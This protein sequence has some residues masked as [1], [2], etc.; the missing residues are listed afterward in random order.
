MS[1]PFR[2]DATNLV[3]RPQTYEELQTRPDFRA[4]LDHKAFALRRVLTD[5]HFPKDVPCGLKS[6]RQPHQHGY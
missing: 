4:P 6:C 3:K 2:D 1:D 5:Y